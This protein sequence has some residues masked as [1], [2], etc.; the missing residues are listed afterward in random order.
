MAPVKPKV[1]RPATGRDPLVGVRLP[2][3][4]LDRI[5]VW[6]KANGGGRSKVIR[7]LIDTAIALGG[8]ADPFAEGKPVRARAVEPAELVQVEDNGRALSA[9]AQNVS[10][11]RA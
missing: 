10:V 4:T 11:R 8:L 3:A 5:D 9:R 2:Q 7:A 6:A 1:G